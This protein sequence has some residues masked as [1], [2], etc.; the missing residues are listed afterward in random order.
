MT[1]AENKTARDGQGGRTSFETVLAAILL[2]LLLI[3][4]VEEY[5]RSV[6]P[7]RES[8]LTVEL[9][10]LR[11]AIHYH[12]V[13][14]GRLPASLNELMLVTKRDIEGEDYILRIIGSF[15]GSMTTDEEGWPLDPFGNRYVYNAATGGVHSST[16]GYEKW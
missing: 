2:F 15:V 6:K 8:A 5:G 11:S 13:L 3:V 16:E 9:S 14:E 10:N 1:A 12:I 7:V 4:A